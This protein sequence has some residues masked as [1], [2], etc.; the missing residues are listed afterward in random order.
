MIASLID[1]FTLLI[2]TYTGAT[3]LYVLVFMIAGHLGRADDSPADF[4]PKKQR[5]IAVMVPA[6]REDAVIEATVLANLRQDYPA[7]H[8]DIFV[9]AD[10][11]QSATLSRLRTLPIQVVE[12]VVAQSSVANALRVG[13]QQ[14]PPY[15]YDIVLI[16]DADNVMATDFLSRINVAFDKGWRSV[17]GHRVAKNVNNTVAILDAASEEINN[18]IFRKGHRAL[19]LSPALIGSGMAFDYALLLDYLSGAQEIGGY[20]KEL[21]MYL[22]QRRIKTAYI[23]DALIYDE[24]VQRRMVLQHQRTRW[25]EAQLQHLKLY[26]FKGLAR[27]F[28]GDFDYANKVI[29]F[30][31]PPRVL[32][33]GLLTVSLLVG[34]VMQQTWF[35]RMIA[36]QLVVLSC[37]L[38][39]SIP[40]SIRRLITFKEILFTLPIVFVTFIVSTFNYRKAKKKFIHTPHGVQ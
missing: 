4:V 25:I 40:H 6:Y 17:Q 15:G 35:S 14:L 30:L 37:T 28:S 23:A 26:F 1:I 21:E 31:M 33:L 7:D 27:F 16:S 29:H 11:F 3:V 22:R 12:V 36:L 34:L 18:H 5:K 10:S 39:L 9:L 38:V 32:L 8:Y 24:K 2:C 19:G 20:D 13:V